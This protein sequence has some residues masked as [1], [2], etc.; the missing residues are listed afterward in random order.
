MDPSDE[1]RRAHH[2]R[3][4]DAFCGSALLSLLSMLSSSPVIAAGQENREYDCRPD[5]KYECTI[6]QCEKIV[7]DFQHAEWF[8]YSTATGE[9][10]AC[11]W[12]NC[13]AAKAT[14]FRD[15]ASGNLTAIGK[16]IPTAHPGNEPIIVSL[17]IDSGNNDDT[18]NFTAVWGYRNE[19]LTFD[20][21]KCALR[22]SP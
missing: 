21:G 19:G 11:L 13:Y 14:V 22:K 8:A 20:M 7:S 4:D 3:R 6:D 18:R 16:L 12:T 17:T 2:G 10:S 1:C 5:I 15:P 9:L